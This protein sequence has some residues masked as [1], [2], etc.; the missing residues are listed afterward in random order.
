MSSVPINRLQLA[1]SRQHLTYGSLASTFPLVGPPSILSQGPTHEEETDNRRWVPRRDRQPGESRAGAPTRSQRI[2]PKLKAAGWRVTPFAP[3]KPLPDYGNQ[4]AVTEFETEAGPAD[5]RGFTANPIDYGEGFRVPFLYSTNGEVIWFHD[6][7]EPLNRSRRLSAFHTP[8]ALREL[9]DRDR[10]AERAALAALSANP[11]LRPYQ[12]EANEAI[13]EAIRDRKRKLLVAMATGTG[14]TVTLVNEV[15]RLMNAGVARRVL[16]LVDRR[17]LAAQAVRTFASFEAEPGLKFDK[18]Y[19]LAPAEFFFR[20]RALGLDL[21]DPPSDDGHRLRPGR[22]LGRGATPDRPV[23]PDLE[24][25]G[26]S[27]IVY[28]LRGGAAATAER[29]VET[30]PPPRGPWGGR[31]GVVQSNPHHAQGHPPP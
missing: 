2:D 25:L 8:A 5:S 21:A 30:A 24:V 9:L 13:E 17:A 31:G 15:Y 7:R 18:I 12:H 4:A 26:A 14:K 28:A 20:C 1:G 29:L 27:A 3:G 11:Y 6:I 23:R 16:F 19:E 10:A 22:G